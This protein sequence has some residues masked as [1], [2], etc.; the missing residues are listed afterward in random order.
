[1]WYPVS[2][3]HRPTGRNLCAD[4]LVLVVLG[5]KVRG[6]AAVG[7]D[8]KRDVVTSPPSEVAIVGRGAIAQRFDLVTGDQIELDR[9]NFL[10]RK[11][12]NIPFVCASNTGGCNVLDFTNNPPDSNVPSGLFAY[13][14]SGTSGDSGAAVFAQN[15]FSQQN[16]KVIGVNTIFTLGPD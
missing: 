13:G 11:Q 10:R 16:F 12:E 8:L 1:R 4:D 15:Q 5:E 7:I 14:Q 6:V 2:S 3:V 9:G